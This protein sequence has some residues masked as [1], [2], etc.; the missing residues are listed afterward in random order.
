MG[1]NYIKVTI[2]C[3]DKELIF[4]NGL[5]Y[6]FIPV[7]CYINFV[8]LSIISSIYNFKLSIFILNKYLVK[9]I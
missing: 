4:E 1:I 3:H 2:S 7:F 8:I 6:L 5:F 9:Y